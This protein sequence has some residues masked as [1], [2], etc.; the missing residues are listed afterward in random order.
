MRKKKDGL[1]LSE[2]I[3][4]AIEKVKKKEN[5][6]HM[7][8]T[9]YKEVID[10]GVVFHLR[11]TNLQREEDGRLKNVVDKVELAEKEKTEADEKEAARDM[12]YAEFM[13]KYV[14]H[15]EGT[16]QND[17]IE[18]EDSDEGGPPAETGSKLK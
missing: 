8:D 16:A 14:A 7:N 5:V 13:E 1:T 9:F 17:R 2:K 12:E 15:I 11:K 3:E 4:K 6:V 10:Q 18:N